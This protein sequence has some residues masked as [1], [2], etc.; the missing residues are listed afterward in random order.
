M[1]VSKDAG[2]KIGTTANLRPGDRVRILDLL[3]GLMLPS[4]NDAAQALAEGFGD[5]ICHDM[6]VKG[7]LCSLPNPTMNQNYSPQKDRFFILKMNKFVRKLKLRNTHYDNPHGLMNKHNYSCA[8]DVC[9][10]MN[11]GMKNYPLF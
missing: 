5:M 1:Y 11:H 2:T 8:E 7:K 10:V 4:G 9:V 3:Y 6:R